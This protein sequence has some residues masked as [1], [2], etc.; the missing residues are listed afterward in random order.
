MVSR[1]L[2]FRL[3]RLLRQYTTGRIDTR[4]IILIL[5]RCLRILQQLP[6]LS[7]LLVKRETLLVVRIELQTFSNLPKYSWQISAES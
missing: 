6:Y 5:L 7:N 3:I 1:E 4:V 2:H